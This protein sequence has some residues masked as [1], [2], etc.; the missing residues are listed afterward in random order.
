MQTL[1][2]TLLTT[3][4]LDVAFGAMTPIGKT[5]TGLRRIAPVTGGAFEGERLNGTVV[6]GADWVLNRADGVMEVDVRLT[7]KTHDDVAIYLSYAGRFLAS[8]DA[9]ARFARG[10]Q[11][12]RNEYSLTTAAKF[13]CGDERYAWLNNVIAIGRGEQIKTGVI[14]RIFDVG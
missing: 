11:L 5:P 9:M 12:D 1:P 3:L 14:Y 2:A 4:T 7:L 6:S 13:E 10:A 8:P